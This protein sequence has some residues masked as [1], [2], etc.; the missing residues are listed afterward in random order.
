[1]SLLKAQGLSKAFGGIR[2]LDTCSISVEEGSITGLIGP[3]GSGKTT[4]F[5]VMTGYERVDSGQVQFHGQSITNK[6]P[7]TQEIQVVVADA[8]AARKQLLE[9]GVD[10][11][12]VDVQPW[13]NFV[14][15]RDPDGNS[16]SLQA[17]ESRPTTR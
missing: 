14:Y 2:A 5:N 8:E 9:A 7:G 4:L 10:A 3:N 1:M 15:F 11:S 16:W 12:E 6:T 13:G 17:I